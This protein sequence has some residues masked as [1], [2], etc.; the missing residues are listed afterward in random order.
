MD[1]EKKT[2]AKDQAKTEAKPKSKGSKQMLASVKSYGAPLKRHG[3]FIFVIFLLAGLAACLL[4]ITQVFSI[5]KEDYRADQEEKVIQTYQLDRAKE[6]EDKVL[7]SQRAGAGPIEP[8][9]D[10]N[11]DNPFVEN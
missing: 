10:P 11:R 1:N 7:Q 5:D 8:N 9:Y 3:Y 6:V 4:L 2:P